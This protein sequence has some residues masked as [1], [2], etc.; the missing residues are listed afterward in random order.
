MAR[1]RL[2]IVMSALTLLAAGCTAP[3]P[4]AGERI[5][6]PETV[7][8][9]GDEWIHE[10]AFSPRDP[11]LV[12]VTSDLSELR[13]FDTAAGRQD[14]EPLQTD[15]TGSY[16]IAFTPDGRTLLVGG[17]G[18]DGKRVGVVELWDVA[19]RKRTRPSLRPDDKF[20]TAVA[21]SPFGSRI[22]TAGGD[23]GRTMVRVW[24]SAT[25]KPGAQWE[26]G[27]EQAIAELAFS[28]D[29]KWLA[30][31]EHQ[32]PGDSTLKLWEAR[33]GKLIGVAEQAAVSGT[34]TFSADGRRIAYP[35][36]Y[37]IV[38]LEV[39]SMRMLGER[40]VG[41]ATEKVTGVAFTP[42]GRTLVGTGES[43]GTVYVWDAATLDVIDWPAQV[44]G[45]T[46]TS[47]RG[48][49]RRLTPPT[50]SGDGRKLAASGTD[51]DTST[52]IWTLP[53]R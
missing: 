14:G 53:Q 44:P 11:L 16:D 2:L 50:I 27:H 24:D 32:G 49:F 3:E 4:D 18:F 28:P 41:E 37:R 29:G 43:Y 40:Y 39:P 34:L 46:F 23:G 7:L 1:T 51:G 30:S 22:A 10:V 15:M 36:I 19:A 6:P 42:D 26:A 17:E 48:P 20:V 52:Y 47:R 12:T 35:S 31:A 9:G 33:T 21:A 38:T 45:R 8:A 5:V 25:G 13:F